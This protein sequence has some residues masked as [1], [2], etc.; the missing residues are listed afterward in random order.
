MMGRV[1]VDPGRGEG[2]GVH[3]RVGRKLQ[4]VWGRDGGVFVMSHGVVEHLGVGLGFRILTLVV[5][6]LHKFEQGPLL[7]GSGP[8]G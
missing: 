3:G 5:N 7:T 6:N 2:G 4:V 8:E 1:G